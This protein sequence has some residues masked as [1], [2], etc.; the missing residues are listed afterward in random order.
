VLALGATGRS[1]TAL[2]APPATRLPTTTLP[3]KNATIPRDLRSAA[4]L[5]NARSLAPAAPGAYLLPAQGR[6]CLAVP[7]T[8]TGQPSR[9]YGV[10]CTGDVDF[11]QNGLHLTF[12]S[13][14]DATVVFVL[15]D[16][17]T[18]PRV[19]PASGSAESV[20]PRNGVVSV[21]GTFSTGD[22]LATTQASGKTREIALPEP[23]RTTSGP[24]DLQDCGGGRIVPIAIGCG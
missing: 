16:G 20:T 15:P 4:S 17:D 1:S 14:T 24:N 10:S 7:D 13:G 21:T 3:A 19:Q 2:G 18:D 12:R 22:T 11:R 9:E 6:W 5:Q 8:K 23:T